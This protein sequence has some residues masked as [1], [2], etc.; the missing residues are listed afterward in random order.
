MQSA[1]LIHKLKSATL[2]HAPHKSAALIVLRL[3]ISGGDGYIFV[4]PA[5]LLQN[6]ISAGDV[7]HFNQQR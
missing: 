4:S 5:D 7:I 1:P 6:A 3:K 2:I